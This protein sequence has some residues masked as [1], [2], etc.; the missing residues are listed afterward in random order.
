MSKIVPAD[1]M[2]LLRSRDVISRACDIRN[3]AFRRASATTRDAHGKRV[4]DYVASHTQR[5]AWP[6]RIAQLVSLPVDEFAREMAVEPVRLSSIPKQNGGTRE[7]VVPTFVRRCISCAL[8]EVLTLT[9]DRMLPKSARA[10][11]PHAENAVREA[12]LDVAEAVSD[13]ELRYFAKLDFRS[14]FTEVRWDTIES[15]L[16]AYGFTEEFVS[17]VMIAV[18]CKVVRRHRG[19]LVPVH[20]DKG[21]QMGVAESAVLANM[22]PHALDSALEA[23]GRRLQY[24]RYSDDLLIGSVDRDEVVWAIR[25]IASWCRQHGLT[26]KGVDHNARLDRLV[27]DVKRNRIDFLGAEI[28]HL[29]YI[30]MPTAKLEAKLNDLDRMSARVSSGPV[31]GISKYGN[32]GGV[33]AFD[34]ADLHRSCSAYLDY[35]RALDPRGTERARTIIKRRFPVTSSA[36]ADERGSIWVAQLWGARMDCETGYGS[37]CPIYGSLPMS[38]H[39]SPPAKGATTTAVAKPEPGDQIPVGESEAEDDISP[40]GPLGWM[41]TEEQ[42]RE[43]VQ[44]DE[45]PYSCPIDFDLHPGTDVDLDLDP[46]RHKSDFRLGS[47]SDDKLD[48]C[49]FAEDPIDLEQAYS[50]D[51]PVGAVGEPAGGASPPRP[52]FENAKFVHAVPVRVGLDTF[53]ILGTCDLRQGSAFNPVVTVIR[54]CRPEVALVR[55]IT[56]IIRMRGDITVAM[57]SKWLAKQL[58]QPQRRLRAPLLF[59]RVIEMHEAARGRDVNIVGG[60]PLPECLQ[61]RLARRCWELGAP[62]RLMSALRAS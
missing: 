61:E 24:Q 25:T 55:E 41:N 59:A 7:I 42:E 52:D 43:R 2:R 20:T 28:D 27:L 45:L 38:T 58:L 14:Y 49:M 31:R 29:G 60:L 30:H 46:N 11:R 10:Y 22:V 47:T 50:V 5:L 6:E 57:K 3:P 9:S 54:N 62:V 17:Y 12:V 13:G 44:M 56:A 19:R 33:D 18:R 51:L 34:D 39:K 40:S 21:T 53:V 15:A 8:S 37:R 4:V 48:S 32:G 1:A 35:W 36:M 26:L 16:H 23:R